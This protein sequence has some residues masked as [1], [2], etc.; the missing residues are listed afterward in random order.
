MNTYGVSS[1]ALA[2]KIAA[3]GKK[4][5]MASGFADAAARI[6]ACSSSDD[7]IIVMGA[8]DVISA[9]EILTA[10]YSDN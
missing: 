9:A 6:Y 5:S 8:G 10:E 7:I 4:I 3:L 2:E 1:A